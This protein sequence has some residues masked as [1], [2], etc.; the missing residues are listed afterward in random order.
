MRGLG[1]GGGA[2]T[3]GEGVGEVRS[4]GKGHCT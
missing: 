3:G 1:F 4:A 2:R